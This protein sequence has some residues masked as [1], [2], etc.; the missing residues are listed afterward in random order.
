MPKTRKYT[1]EAVQHNEPYINTGTICPV[2]IRYSRSFPSSIKGT[3]ILTRCS[4][5]FY[6][7]GE[8]EPTSSISEQNVIQFLFKNI[9]CRFGVSLQIITDN[10]TQF[11]GKKVKKFCKDS[12]IKL[13]FALVYQPQANGQVEVTN[14]TITSILKK[15]VG[16]NP[17]T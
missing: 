8:A 13:S 7:M 9:I 11:T 3:E 4:Q 16:D 2:G 15:K 17:G 6:E 14:R 1:K 5:L 10:R 12:G